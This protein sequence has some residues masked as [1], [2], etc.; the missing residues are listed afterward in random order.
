MRDADALGLGE[1]VAGVDIATTGEPAGATGSPVCPGC[2]WQATSR[3]TVRR[4][5]NALPRTADG[6]RPENTEPLVRRGNMG[7]SGEPC[8]LAFLNHI[9]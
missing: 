4:P 2:D 5:P 7:T 3:P 6:F 1:P 9:R 8:G